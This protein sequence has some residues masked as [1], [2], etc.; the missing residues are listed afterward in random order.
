MVRLKELLHQTFI[1]FG[2]SFYQRLVHLLGAV[3]LFG[4]NFLYRRFSPVGRPRELFHQD[5]INQGVEVWS[6]TDG[7]LHRH[8][9][10]TIDVLQVFDDSFIVAVFT[11]QLVDQKNDRLAQLLRIAKVILRSHF[12]S[13][14]AIDEQHR[15]VGHV[16]RRHGCTDKIIR[17][18]AVD[19][20][21]F[22]ALP[23]HMKSRGKHRI[24]I[25]LFHR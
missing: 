7:I 4:R 24:A 11:I 23:F 5:D 25:L 10:W 18:R 22:F 2:R 9:L 15:R 21:E 6:R 20:V 3:T 8:H 12:M 1:I 13:K 17:T 19:D 14:A 16:Q